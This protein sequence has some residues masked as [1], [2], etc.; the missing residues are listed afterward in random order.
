MHANVTRNTHKISGRPIPINNFGMQRSKLSK[1][2][3]K[4]RGGT[5]QEGLLGVPRGTRQTDWAR[6]CQHGTFGMR[7]QV[8]S[9][10]PVFGLSSSVYD[11]GPGVGDARCILPGILPR[12]C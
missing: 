9:D 7:V 11:V 12:E 3:M 10:L 6:S 1:Y 4:G 5:H 8:G 2:L